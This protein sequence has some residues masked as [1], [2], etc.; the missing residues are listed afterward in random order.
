LPNAEL[1]LGDIFLARGDLQLA[2]EML[3][4][5]ERFAHDPST[6]AWMRFRYLIRLSA[7][8]G[9]LALAQGDH[10]GARR[11]AQRCIELATR[12]NARKN[13]VK[14]WRLAGEAASAA[15]QWSDAEH[16][17]GQARAIAQS[18][19]NPTQLWRT[20][21]ALAR[22]HAARG[23]EDATRL[24]AADGASVVDAVLA[25]LRDETLRASLE[26]LALVRE[27]RARVRDG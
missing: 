10:D 14:G 21:A 25:G 13:L 20:Y 26:R 12:T 5:V 4:G 8:L 16:A 3:E 7:S 2:R 1:N 15:R 6:S 11:Q 18:I 19:G 24:A 22:F 27:L 23:D 9:E 17:L